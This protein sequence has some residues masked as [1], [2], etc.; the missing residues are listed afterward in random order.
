MSIY[1]IH[2]T[3]GNDSNIGSEVNPWLTLQTAVNRLNAG[4]TLILKDGIYY[5]TD[6]NHINYQKIVGSASYITIKAQN[7][8]YAIMDGQ[9]VSKYAVQFY[10]GS[11]YLKFE[12]IT[13]RNYYW[14]GF[15]SNN[16]TTGNFVHHIIISDC[17]IYDIGRRWEHESIGI[18]AVFIGGGDHHWIITRCLVY[19]I[20][21]TQ[22]TEDRMNKDHF[23]YTHTYTAGD[24]NVAHDNEYSYNIIYNTSGNMF[25]L[26]S[27]NDKILNNVSAWAFPNS[28]SQGIW[29]TAHEDSHG[30]NGLT[31]ANNIIY[32]VNDW[33]Q[34]FAIIKTQY[35]G[36]AWVV[37]NNI[38]CSPMSLWYPGYEHPE[39]MAGNNY[40]IGCENAVIDPMFV[41]AVKA[42]MYN[43][44]FRLKAGSPAINA[45]VSVG[46]T[47]DF[48]KSAIVGNPDIGAYEYNGSNGGTVTYYSA[49]KSQAFVKND[50]GTGYYGSSVL[51]T[52]PFA[53]YTSTVDQQ[54][55][56]A[57]ALAEIAA[58]GQ[59]YANT[60]GT[61]L[62]TAIGG[63]TSINEYFTLMADGSIWKMICG[64]FEKIV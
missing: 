12:G 18:N 17:K 45:G 29:L 43:S 20:G 40:G 15:F 44:D 53:K 51:Y 59:D 36:T 50:C 21:R 37:K 63:K 54:T 1:Y 42:D 3:A 24:P 31:I 9:T 34:K 55:A 10:P 57:L 7:K 28:I 60:N 8:G 46:L 4:D 47:A 32:Q 38:V 27:N 35:G 58:D 25:N 11:C 2:P 61:C 19:N 48:L 14:A 26:C 22:F 52:V 13:I 39:W 16:G 49:E 64:A 33:D 30:G 23:V 5:S 41:Y 62:V 56:D 6:E